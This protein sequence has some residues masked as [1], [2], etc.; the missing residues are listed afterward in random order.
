MNWLSNFFFGF[1]EAVGDSEP[2]SK[3]GKNRLRHFLRVRR[4]R[5][6]STWSK[7]AKKTRR[8]ILIGG[9][10]VFFVAAPVFLYM[11][12]PQRAKDAL[13][14]PSLFPAP[15]IP[16]AP[17]FNDD[18]MATDP[19]AAPRRWKY[20]VV[21]HS[22]SSRG[23]AQIFDQSHRERGWRCLGYHFV[24]GNGTDQ[25]D[26]SVI[27]GPRWYSQEA[28]AHAHSTEHNEFGVGICLVGNFDVQHPTPAQWSS[29]VTLVAK[30]SSQ[31]SIP[32]GNIVGHSQIR[33]GGTTACPGKNF[34]IQAL[35]ETVSAMHG[36]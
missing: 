30:L 14:T 6:K 17:V 21:H 9:A 8:R 22:A 29:L 32:P 26:G 3:R 23:S 5:L 33:Q 2:A 10:L 12:W 34:P 18:V 4:T 20:I 11:G 31:Y 24:I 19:A 16:S 35:R 27:A 36:P 25:G 1:A 15:S 13:F 7:I 28:G